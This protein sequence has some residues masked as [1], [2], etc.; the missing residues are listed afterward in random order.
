MD[1]LVLTSVAVAAF[2]DT[3]IVT[4][5]FTYGAAISA[6]ALVAFSNGGSRW[7]V[8]LMAIS[9]VL[10][11]EAI[12]VTLSRLGKIDKIINS[13]R[14]KMEKSERRSS[15]IL[16]KFTHRNNDAFIL[17]MTK[18]LIFRFIALTRPIN[19]ISFYSENRISLKNV[20]IVFGISIVW[21]FFWTVLFDQIS[22][23]L[24]G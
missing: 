21:V 6:A 10:V 2:L 7:E 5:F 8:F 15:H 4:G 1:E 24:S 16:I 22:S 19:L 9:G 13:A 18:L 20:L 14:I 23:I 12:N 11:A 17:Q 3:W